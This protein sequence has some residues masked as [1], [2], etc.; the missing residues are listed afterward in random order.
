MFV[1]MMLVEIMTMMILMMVM[2]I[3]MHPQR[4]DAYISSTTELKP[5]ACPP[6]PK[7][8]IDAG[9]H[10]SRGKQKAPRQVIR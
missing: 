5:L 1:I 10:V 2:M 6:E 9:T 7:P 4:F 8:D 3:T